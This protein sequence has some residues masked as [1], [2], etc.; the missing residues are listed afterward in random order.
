MRFVALI[1]GAF[2]LMVSSPTYG[3][4]GSDYSQKKSKKLNLEVQIKE[5]ERILEDLIKQ[6]NGTTDPET[7][8]RVVG[9][10]TAVHS[11]MLE[12]IQ[13]YNKVSKDLEYR[14]PEKG[15]DSKRKYLPMRSRSLEQ[16]EKEMGLD[17]VLSGAKE[18]VDKK[19]APIVEEAKK[20]E[21]RARGGV[22]PDIVEA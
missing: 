13:D 14:Y 15:D 4:G 7:R 1:I 6:K 21:K 3:A 2:F 19:Y 11:A 12:A 22:D 9:E 18:R 8:R 16:I 20:Q 5:R 10:M 17:A